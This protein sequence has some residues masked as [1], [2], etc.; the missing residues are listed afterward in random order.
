MEI[1]SWFELA[2][3][4]NIELEDKLTEIMKS[5]EQKAKRRKMKSASEKCE[6]VSTE[7]DIVW[8]SEGKKRKVQ[9]IFKEIMAAKLLKNINLYIQECLMSFKQDKHK[10]IYRHI[11]VKMELLFN[12]VLEVLARA[13]N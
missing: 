2:E 12:I 9:K 4:I 11:I 6:T 13:I 3:E 8:I 7:T 10:E 1:N 5:K